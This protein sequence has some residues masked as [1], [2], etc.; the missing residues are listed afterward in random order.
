MKLHLREFAGVT[1]QDAAIAALI[2][3]GREWVED[4]T[5]RALIDQ[6]WR[7]TLGDGP[8][9]PA[10]AETVSTTSDRSAD[11]LLRK[12]PVLAITKFVTVDAVGA[13][14][15]VDAATYALYEAESKWPR[16]IAATGATWNPATTGVC[17]RVEF[18]A[19][20]VNLVG[21][22]TVGTVPE[23][24]K[25]AIKLWVEANYDRDEKMMALLLET[26]ECLIR[27]ERAEHGF[28]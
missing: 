11:I 3:A 2:Q 14:T 7:L 1:E 15:A 12:S 24:F 23:R 17:M 18:R 8:F 19:G 20:F 13:E 28:A 27:P 22:P 16:L 21:S 26:A 4:Y 9:V 5:G 10:D 25:Q 6:K